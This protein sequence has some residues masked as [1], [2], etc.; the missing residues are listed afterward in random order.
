MKLFHFISAGGLFLRK[1]EY[2]RESERCLVESNR[3]HDGAE[4]QINYCICMNVYKKCI[5]KYI[6]QAILKL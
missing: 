6:V 3:I 1:P 5:E 2:P 4:K